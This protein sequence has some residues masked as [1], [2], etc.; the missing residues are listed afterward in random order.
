MGKQEAFGL[1]PRMAAAVL[2]WSSVLLTLPSVS[3]PFQVT[4]FILWAAASLI[5]H[6]VDCLPFVPLLQAI[7]QPRKRRA[8]SLVW[9]LTNRAN[10]SDCKCCSSKEETTCFPPFKSLSTDKEHV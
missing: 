2:P 9:V 7:Q 5:F 6:G 3:A 8:V 4:P 10:D 1:E